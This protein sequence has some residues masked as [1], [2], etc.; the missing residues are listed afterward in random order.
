MKVILI[1]FMGSGKTSVGTAL[2]KKLSLPLIDLDLFLEE[3]TGRKIKDIFKEDGEAAF[4]SFETASLKEVLET[5]KDFVLSTGGG[6]V[7]REENGLLLEKEPLVIYL[8]AS[9][10]TILKRLQTDEERPLLFGSDKKERI[11]TLLADRLSAYTSFSK[12][13][14]ETDGKTVEEI[15]EECIS[16]L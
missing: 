15:A 1:G 12:F 13:Q 4:R 9:P 14:I 8:K 10:D 3:K 11:R 6:V 16:Y 7:V 2:S 5:E